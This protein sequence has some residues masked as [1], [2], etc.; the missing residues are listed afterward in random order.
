[1]VSLIPDNLFDRAGKII[2]M[3]PKRPR[4]ALESDPS[5]WLNQ[6]EAIRPAGV[7][8]FDL[9]VEAIDKSWKLDMQLANA[10]TSNVCAL[11][12]VTGTAKQNVFTDVALHLP[13]V[14]RMSFKDVDG[15]EVDLALILVGQFVQ[16]GNLP[17]KWRSRIAAEDENDWLIRPQT[18]QSNWRFVVEIL[19]G[20]VRCGAAH[21]QSALARLRPHRFKGKEEVGGH[22]HSRHYPAESLRRLMHG[23]VNVA[24]KTEPQA[25]ESRSYADKPALRPLPDC[26]GVQF[27][28]AGPPISR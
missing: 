26:H 27:Y 11:L 13:D 22:R 3:E 21:V 15:V 16:G 19:D 28:L 6:V 20:E 9:V 5:I 23:P 4:L 18:R 8:R 17:P 10:G 7:C 25:E 2:W 14:G 24:N 1:M 12:L